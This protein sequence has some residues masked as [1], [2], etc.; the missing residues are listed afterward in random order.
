MS[1]KHKS[2]YESKYVV[3]P[4]YHRHEANRICCEG[5]GSYNTVNLVFEDTKKLKEY[6]ITFCNS[7]EGCR[8]CLI[9]IALNK[10]YGVQYEL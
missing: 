9:H 10:K 2:N 6:G 4:Y 7:I 3:C 5:T 8:S 1:S